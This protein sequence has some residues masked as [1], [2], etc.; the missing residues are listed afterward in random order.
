MGFVS[1]P[2]CDEDISDIAEHC[3]KCGFPFALYQSADS[4]EPDP[5]RRVASNPYTPSPLLVALSQNEDWRIRA[6]VAR[7]PSAP[8][9]LLWTLSDD[10]DESVRAAVAENGA[11]PLPILERL[12]SDTAM[13]VVNAVAGNLGTP[14]YILSMV[15]DRIVLLEEDE[16]SNDGCDCGNDPW[17]DDPADQENLLEGYYSSRRGDF[18]VN[19]SGERCDV[20]DTSDIGGMR[21]YYDEENSCWLEC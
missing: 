19:E 8:C 2:E 13:E 4:R 3:P 5:Y 10:N 18:Y 9:S 20:M 6:S 21:M 11:V 15:E 17:Y 16:E 7:N 12:A 1:C 14:A